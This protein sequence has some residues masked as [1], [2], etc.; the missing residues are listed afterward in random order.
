MYRY[1]QQRSTAIIL[2]TAWRAR[3]PR[4]QYGRLHAAA[5]AVQAAYQGYRVRQA[6]KQSHAFAVFL[7]SCCR[8]RRQRAVFL[9]QKRAAI[10]LQAAVRAWQER[11]R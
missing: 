10:A 3:Q 4:V 9:D 1:Q 6:I 8:C 7:Q 2:Q 5:Q 11:S